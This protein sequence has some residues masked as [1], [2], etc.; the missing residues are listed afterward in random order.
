M[1]MFGFTPKLFKKLEEGFPKF[2]DDHKDNL[3]KC[4]YLIPTIVF[5]QIEDGEVTVE[6]LKT[7]AVWQGITYK[8]DKDKV[9]SE[10]KK[11]VDLGEYPVGVWE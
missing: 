7:N 8:E 6:V 2:L 11:L 5:N 4:E 3:L 9:V 10:I 1:N